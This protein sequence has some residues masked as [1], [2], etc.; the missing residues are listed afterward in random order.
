MHSYSSIDMTAVGKK[1]RFS[2]SDKSDFEM[3]NSQS[4]AVHAFARCVLVSFSIDETLLSRKD[5]LVHKFQ[6]PNI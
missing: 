6:R 5:E 1:L 4:I 3:I 2:L